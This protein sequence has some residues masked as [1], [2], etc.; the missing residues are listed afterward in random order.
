MPPFA[1]SRGRY[2][3]DSTHIGVRLPVPADFDRDGAV[4][5]RAVTELAIEIKPPA[6]RLSRRRHAAAMQAS[7]IDRCRG[8]PAT[9]E[10][11]YEASCS[12]AVTELSRA[13]RD[14]KYATFGGL[15]TPYS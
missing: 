4:C 6:V 5:S 11:G 2:W 13:V 8:V 14:S 3:F 12:C 9:D 15:E 10:R 1:A 7:A